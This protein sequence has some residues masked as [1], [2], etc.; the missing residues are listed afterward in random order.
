MKVLRVSSIL[1]HTEL[2]LTRAHN[3]SRRNFSV[4]TKC[5]IDKGH[6][7]KLAPITC[8]SLAL[9]PH[10]RVHNLLFT[11]THNTQTCIHIS[12]ILH[13]HHSHLTHITHTHTH[14]LRPLN[15]VSPHRVSLA[16]ELL[17]G[18]LHQSGG[19]TPS[20][21]PD[22]STKEGG[23]VNWMIHTSFPPCDVLHLSDLHF[24]RIA[25]CSNLQVPSYL[26]CTV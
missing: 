22:T 2:V 11:C 19:S 16:E 8:T 15:S 5:N 20:S 14:F 1:L 10:T 7:Y 24:L 9:S 26:F 6:N 25:L 18:E 13:T 17:V 12:H 23:K 21:S 3:H 4:R